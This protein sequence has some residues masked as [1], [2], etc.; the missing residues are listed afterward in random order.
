MFGGEPAPL[1]KASDHLRRVHLHAGAH[2][3]R[4]YTAANILALGGG[5]LRL[6]DGAHQ[7]VIVLSQLLGAEGHLADGAVDDVGLV[8]T[9]LHLTSLDLGDG[10]GHVG[11]DGAGLGGGH[12]PLGP[13]T[14]PRRPTTPI[15][16]GVATTTSKSNQFSFWIFSTRS[17]SPTKS[18]RRHGPRRPWRPWQRPARAGSYRCVG[19]DDGAADLLVSVAGVNAQLH[20]ELNGLVELGGSGLDQQLHGLVGIVQS[21]LV[22]LLGA[23]L[24]FLASKHCLHPPSEITK[25]FIIRKEHGTITTSFRVLLFYSIN[26]YKV[27]H[28]AK[29]I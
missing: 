5:R 13:R 19:E 18:H 7:R 23:L 3:G 2:G 17:M 26:L 21:V 12:Q 14:L 15:M 10:L 16:S 22:D 28:L 25:M 8:Q 11:G 1:R 9:V 29:I 27:Y 20:M 4:G 6:H 24:I